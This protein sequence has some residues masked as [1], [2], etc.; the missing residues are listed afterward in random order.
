MKY[1]IGYFSP[2]FILSDPPRNNFFSA[3]TDEWENRKILCSRQ[4]V[5]PARG[6]M[7]GHKSPRGK[8]LTKLLWKLYQKSLSH[9]TQCHSNITLP[10]CIIYFHSLFLIY[11]RNDKQM[12]N[13]HLAK[14]LIMTLRGVNNYSDYTL[15][16]KFDPCHI[17]HSSCMTWYFFIY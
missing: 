6:E 11:K 1:F 4:S 7:S 14:K 8:I 9:V 17:I 15:F 10:I 2:F 12:W 13:V 16:W 5:L 3:M